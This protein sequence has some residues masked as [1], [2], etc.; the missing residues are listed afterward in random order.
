MLAFWLVL[1]YD[2][3]QDR[4]TI[5]VIITTFSICVLKWR[6]VLRIIYYFTWLGKSK[7]QKSLVQAFN[8]YEKQEVVRKSRFLF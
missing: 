2:L 5:D 4:R 7:V 3:L 1:A 8:R 6:K